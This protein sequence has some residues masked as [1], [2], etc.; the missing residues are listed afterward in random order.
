MFLEISRIHQTAYI[1][2]SFR[3]S[4]MNKT[5]LY[6]LPAVVFWGFSYIAI[7]M[8]LTELEPVE[9]ISARFLMAGIVLYGIIKFQRK[10][11]WPV[12]MKWHLVVAAGIVFLHFWVM[13]TGMKDTTASNTAWIL[14]TAPIFIALLSWAYLS[15]KFTLPQWLGLTLACIGMLALVYNGSIANFQWIHSRG[16]LIVLGSCVTWALYTVST[17]EITAR[18][19]PIVATFWMVTIAGIVFV[20]YTLATSGYHKFFALHATTT[21]ALIFLGVFCLALAFWLWSEGLMRQ[22]A[23]EVGVYLYIEPI[24]TMIGAWLLLN[25]KITFWLIIGAVLISAGVYVGER[26]GRMKIVEH[27]A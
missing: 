5:A 11:I 12:A 13:A 18:V 21:T 25:E 24:F 27:D 14:T 17:R 7:K 1:R 19:D 4:G 9:M 2:P 15:E 6:L 16:D 10:R 8:V 26:Y 22:P 20:P 3:K 23:A